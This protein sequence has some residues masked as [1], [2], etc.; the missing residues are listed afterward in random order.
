MTPLAFDGTPNDTP[1]G[2]FTYTVDDD[3]WAWSEGLY[4][5][6]G[7]GPHE[8]EATTALMLQHKHPEDTARAL[9][10]LEQAIRDG[11]AFSCYHRIIDTHGRVRSV[12]SVGRGLLG[13]H[14]SVEQVTGFFVDLTAVIRSEAQH[15]I[16]EA[17]IQISKTRSMIDQAKGIVMVESGCDADRAFAI[18]RKASSYQNVKLNELSRR[19][20]EKVSGSAPHLSHLAL[21]DVLN[22]SP[23]PAAAALG[24]KRRDRASRELIAELGSVLS[25]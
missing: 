4:A 13:S 6:H 5:L 16:D 15:E 1:V 7:Y 18:L 8:V 23:D 19:L 9:D 21:R 11:E 2:Y 24:P 10:V 17:L 22:R 25:D 12:L 3:H 14:G 20:V